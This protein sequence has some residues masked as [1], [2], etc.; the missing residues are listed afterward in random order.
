[1]APLS[2]SKTAAHATRT[3]EDRIALANLA[4]L[5]GKLQAAPESDLLRRFVR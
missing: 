1:M 5:E 3:A 2:T 4:L